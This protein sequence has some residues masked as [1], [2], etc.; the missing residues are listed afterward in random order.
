[1]NDSLFSA[2]RAT[3]YRCYVGRRTIDIRISRI[4]PELD[5]LLGDNAARTWCFITAVNPQSRRLGDEDNARRQVQ[6]R[7]ELEKRGWVIF[8]GEGI[9][10]DDTWPA[11]PSFLVLGICRDQAVGLARRFDQAAIVFGELGGPAELVDCNAAC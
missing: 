10:D 6:L 2:Y 3:T 9:G 7:R 4:H 5:A 8:E 1:M 11:E